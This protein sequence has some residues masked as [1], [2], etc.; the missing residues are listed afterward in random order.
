MNNVWSR[1]V[2][3]SEE[4]YRSRALRFNDAN[5]DIWLR[6]LHAESGMNILEIGC[7]GGIFCHRI[8]TYLPNTR[9][10][11]LDFDTGHIEYAKAKSKELGIGCE[12][13]NGDATDLPFA[14]NTF[15]LC[16][17]HTV[18]EHI[19][20]EKFLSEQYRVLKPNGRIVVLSVRTKMGLS[21]DNSFLTAPEE[22]ELFEKAWSKAGDFDKENN[23]GAY[24]LKEYDFPA[25]LERAGFYDVNVDFIAVSSFCPD[26]ANISDETAAEQIETNR[27]HTLTSVE[28]ALRIAPDGLSESE[29]SKLYDLINKR[30]DKRIEQYKNGEKQWDFTAAVTLVASGRK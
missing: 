5:K 10:T 27:L 6:A 16:F 1:F 8:K 25:V 28:K 15:D 20:T 7:G 26:N 24:E 18:I 12:F 29:K 23:I 30:Y 21:D 14:E 22:K 3:T 2:Q 4:L 13:I 11:G 17:S 19:P 9:V